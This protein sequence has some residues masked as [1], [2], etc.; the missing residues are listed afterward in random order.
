M[1]Y[2]CNQ[3]RDGQWAS[4]KY[5]IRKKCIGSD[6][7]SGLQIILRQPGPEKDEQGE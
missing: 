7:G 3:G 4:F 6:L 1:K 5:K 2:V